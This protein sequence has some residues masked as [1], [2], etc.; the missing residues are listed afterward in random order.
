MSIRVECPETLL[1]A[2]R[3]EPTAFARKVMIY[4]LGHLYQ[5]GKISSGIGAQVLGCDRLEFYRLLSEHGFAVLHYTPEELEEEARPAERLLHGCSAHESRR[6]HDAIT[7]ARVDAPFGP[8]AALFAEVLIPRA[9]YEAVAV[10]G[11]GRTGATALTPVPWLQIREPGTSPTIEPLLLGL[12]AGELQGLLLACEVHPDGVFIDARLGRRRPAACSYRT[13]G[14]VGILLAALH[15]GLLTRQEAM[16]AVQQLRAQGFRL[17]PEV[18][19]W[20]EE[21]GERS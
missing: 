12:D 20:F 17:S 8:V 2:A 3:E 14:T 1:V 18:V 4:T 13:E 10:Q 21:G 5:Q 6:E 11:A 19:V 15:A 16:E 7:R 9:V